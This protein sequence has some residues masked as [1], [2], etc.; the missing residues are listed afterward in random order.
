MIFKANADIKTLL[1][2]N[3]RKMNSKS[4]KFQISKQQ[5]MCE[6]DLN[7]LAGVCGFIVSFCIFTIQKCDVD[8]RFSFY[9]SF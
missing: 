5:K 9:V 4:L 6:E 8:V 1:M 7:A 3:Q 2:L